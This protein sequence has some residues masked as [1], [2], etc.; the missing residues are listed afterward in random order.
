MGY[1]SRHAHAVLDFQLSLPQEWAH[2]EPR[3]QA[4][5]VPEDV[6]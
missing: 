4:C 5:H 6:S 2:D 3:R 1:V